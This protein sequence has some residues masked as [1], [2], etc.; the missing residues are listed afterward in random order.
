MEKGQRTYDPIVR[1]EREDL[2]DGIDVLHDVLMREDDAFGVAGTTAG[3]DYG[4]D[5]LGRADRE[6]SSRAARSLAAARARS[7]AN[8]RCDWTR[9]STKMTGKFTA[10]IFLEVITVRIS[11]LT[12]RSSHGFGSGA[13]IQIHGT[14][15]AR[16]NTGVDTARR[17]PTRAAGSTDHFAGAGVVANPA[18]EQNGGGQRAAVG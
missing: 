11:A 12:D 14:R 3:K 16:D 5:G 7:L 18:A 17:L 9:S 6:A 13:E 10:G 15:P 1:G 2:P 4:G 8:V